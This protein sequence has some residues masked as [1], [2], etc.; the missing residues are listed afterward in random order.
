MA[1]INDILPPILPPEDGDDEFNR[2]RR[3]F[4]A[5]QRARLVEQYGED[6][7]EQVLEMTKLFADLI[8]VG[9][10]NVD[11]IKAGVLRMAVVVNE[12]MP[13]LD[14]PRGM[15][16]CYDERDLDGALGD[17]PAN[18]QRAFVAVVGGVLLH[19]KGGP[20]D[21]AANINDNVDRLAALVRSEA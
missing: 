13:A 1:D 19:S 21:S 12:M 6:A 2:M 5:E 3:N 10:D 17:I 8:V 9:S 7:V 14:G 11:L 15:T 18:V 16:R 20:F 4:L